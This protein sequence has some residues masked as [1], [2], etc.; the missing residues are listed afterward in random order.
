MDTNKVKIDLKTD[1][2]PFAETKAKSPPVWLYSVPA[3]AK[4]FKVITIARSMLLD[5]R[6]W[7]KKDLEKGC[8]AVARYELA[9]FATSMGKIEKDLIKNSNKVLKKKYSKSEDIV[10][11]LQKEK[12]KDL[13]KVFD[14]CGKDASKLFEKI[15]KAITDKVSIALDEVETDKGD[16]RKSLGAAKD[17]LRRIETVDF[18]TTFGGPSK[19]AAG[20]M[21]KL[22][23]ALSDPN[24]AVEPKDAIKD[25]LKSM[26]DAESDF[27]KKEKKASDAIRA[28]LDL[29]DKMEND[30]NA[31][32]SLNKLGETIGSKSPVAKALRRVKKD[33]EAMT[34]FLDDFKNDVS[35]AAN[36]AG[37]ESKVKA[38]A[39]PMLKKASLL[40]MKG[41]AYG[42][43]SVDALKNVAEFKTKYKKLSK[44]LK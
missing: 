18:K 43:S 3:E 20:A 37:D 31:D 14:S 22:S 24:G 29:G 34:K 27:E 28:F 25:A 23:K 9:I 19:Q 10:D 39:G 36:V 12:N 32:P 17:A 30:K 8:Y 7:K 44:D 4:K 38:L 5:G 6:K 26:K 33:M 41:L 16:N 11:L 15:H 40:E 35:S 42:K 2:N 13:Q 21:A 1:I